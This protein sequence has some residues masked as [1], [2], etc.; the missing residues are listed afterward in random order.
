[1]FNL[2]IST[3]FWVFT[4]KMDIK[5]FKLIMW[6]NYLL[7]FY[8]HVFENSFLLAVHQNGVRLSFVTKTSTNKYIYTKSARVAP[9]SWLSEIESPNEWVWKRETIMHG[10]RENESNSILSYRHWNKLFMNDWIWL[11]RRQVQLLLA[12]KRVYI[13]TSI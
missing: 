2:S 3:S 6:G 7:L 4:L 10:E 12:T 13:Y 5:F 8:V 1:M 9:N 11:I